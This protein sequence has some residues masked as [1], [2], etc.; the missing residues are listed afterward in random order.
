MKKITL[1]KS[2]E[3]PKTLN[4][5]VDSVK[6]STKLTSIK[7]QENINNKIVD[8]K[9][10]CKI[11]DKYPYNYNTKIGSVSII[12]NITQEDVLRVYNK[13]DKEVINMFLNEATLLEKAMTNIDDINNTI[14][15]L[16]SRITLA[17]GKNCY[18]FRKEI[19]KNTFSIQ[20]C[21]LFSSTSEN[22]A[23]ILAHEIEFY[24]LHIQKGE[25]KDKQTNNVLFKFQQNN[26]MLNIIDSYLL[27][28][29][30]KMIYDLILKKSLI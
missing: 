28:A 2:N 29:N 13:N 11:D 9:E 27:D 6:N 17:K 3:K 10:Y 23:K 15:I 18:C 30:G 19:T 4:K 12:I 5:I 14:A 16:N 7:K 24:D 22:S 25:I 21:K 20:G 8:R 1:K 26:E